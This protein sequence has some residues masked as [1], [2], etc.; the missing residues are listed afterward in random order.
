M[1]TQRLYYSDSYITMFDATLIERATYQDAPAVILDRTCFYPTSGGQP[2]DTGQL[3]GLPVVDVA[4]RESDGAVLHVLDG[5]AGPLEVAQVS[6]AVDWARRFDHMRLHTGQHILSQAFV[7]V[8]GAETVGFHISPD[9][10]TID[11]NMT[12]LPPAQVDAA[13]DLANRIVAENCPVRAWFPSDEELAK[14]LPRLRKVPEVEGKFR[15]VE[16]AEFDMTACGGTHVARAGEIGVIKVLRADKRGD[17]VRVEFRCGERALLDYRQKN[18]LVNRLAVELTT[19]YDQIP[20]ALAKLRD[21]NRALRRELK[22]LRALA[23]DSEAE[24]LWEAADK[25]G[26]YVLITAAFG[27]YDAGE[28]RQI[29]QKLIAHPKTIAI[30]GAAG[31]K[32]QLIAARSIDLPHD[33]VAAL[34]AGLAVWGVDRGG[35]RPEFAQG[36]GVAASVNDVEKALAAAAHAAR[37]A[38]GS[39]HVE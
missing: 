30:C 1:T 17:T 3:S 33:M 4:I 35:G 36:G 20:A 24:K 32:A 10:V 8:A 2:H 23:V 9:S 21:E 28:V 19:G 18:A 13:E 31:E 11:L 16:I 34:M 39:I 14:I 29:V 6:G 22:A 26:A 37:G 7:V 27:E 5:A 15:V 12:S 38:S 25:T